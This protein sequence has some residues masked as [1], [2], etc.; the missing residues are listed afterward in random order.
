M[1]GS[2]VRGGI[3]LV[4]NG[5]KDYQRGG[6]LS[7][8]EGIFEPI[9]IEFPFEVLVEPGVYLG[10]GKFYGVGQT[11]QE[12]RRCNSPLCLRN[13]FF[14]KAVHPALEILVVPN[15]VAIYL[16][17]LDARDGCILE[18]RIYQQGGAEFVPLMV[19]PLLS[20]ILSSGL[21]GFLCI[22]VIT[23]ESSPGGM[24][25]IYQNPCDW[26]WTK[27]MWVRKSVSD[28]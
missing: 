12:V 16:E 3:C 28:K 17:E 15:L 23:Q 4:D 20:R 27:Y 14:P 9:G 24:R 11:I 7:S 26:E 5:G 8:Y 1:V 6:L 13:Q 18:S 19:N 2:D 25:D 22:I 21:H 10:V